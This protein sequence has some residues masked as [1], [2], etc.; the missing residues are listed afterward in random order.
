MSVPGREEGVLSALVFFIVV[1]ASVIFAQWKKQNNKPTK[2]KEDDQKVTYADVRV[3]KQQGNQMEQTAKAEAEVEYG[4][5]K[6]SKRPR[7]TELR[8]DDCM[9]AKIQKVR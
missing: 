9:Y 5:V 7:H 1:G 4:Q 3:M 6:F 8:G 2:E